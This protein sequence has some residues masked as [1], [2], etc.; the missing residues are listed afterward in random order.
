MTVLA[1]ATAT[2][3]RHH[4]RRRRSRPPAWVVLPLVAVC[5]LAVLPVAYV[6]WHAQAAG[7]DQ[8]VH[9]LVRPY[10]GQL[11]VN[12]VLLTVA[13]MIGCLLLGTAT[14]FLVERT[15]VPG[16][17]LWRAVLP[18]PL[19]V[20]AFI[21]TYG[22]VSLTRD[23]QGYWGAVVVLTLAYFP[24]VELPV[25]AA[26]RGLDPSWRETARGLGHGPWSVLRRLTIPLLRP[27]LAAGGLL[28][29]LHILAEF[30]ALSL[31]RFRTFTTAIFTQYQ[32]TFDSAAAAMLAGVLIVLCAV[33]L[34]VELLARGRARYARVGSGA[35][36]PAPP[37]R[38]GR[39]RWAAVGFLAAV[40][41]VALGVPVGTIV[42]WA[43]AG[44]STV[45]AWGSLLATAVHSVV[46]SLGGALLAAALAVPVALVAV[47]HG[48]WI[49]T[50]VERVSYLG[51]S[52]P[53]LVVALALVFVTIRIV[54]PLYQSRWLVMISYA[55][56]FL[57]LAVAT[58]RPRVAQAPVQLEEQARVLGR[59]P[60]QA[61]LAVT[62]PAIA[63]GVGAAAALVFLASMRE[64]TAT[65]LLRPS[66]VD[67][68]ATQVWSLTTNISYGAAA[69]YALLLILVSAPATYLLTKGERSGRSV[70]A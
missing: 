57:P 43:V 55:A 44:S 67:T 50:L 63:P 48:G 33:A 68:L 45:F 56:L 39:G 10:V 7:W 16:R 37:A 14:A 51:G 8:S 21:T 17:G 60:W 24:L 20:P 23:V 1:P 41:V 27:A 42:Y 25:A 4:S 70:A 13:V 69:P 52:L 6:I 34:T 5:V 22:W 36:R 49:A 62:L 18:L 2:G 53:G 35:P 66:G 54:E 59:R 40:L 58:V 11:L 30:G 38:L 9:L 31:L 28:V 29:A 26:L 64:L 46:F 12:T 15:D 65:L 3:R 47:R 19:A 61:T 32:L